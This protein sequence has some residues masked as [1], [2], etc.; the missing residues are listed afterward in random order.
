MDKTSLDT[1][2]GS[3]FV[4][5]DVSG[6]PRHVKRNYAPLFGVTESNVDLRNYVRR[7]VDWVSEHTYQY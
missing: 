2:C 4:R 3:L 7:D 6:C 1:S 5:E